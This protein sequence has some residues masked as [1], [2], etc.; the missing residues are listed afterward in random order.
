[1][2]KR[3]IIAILIGLHGGHLSNEQE[4]HQTNKQQVSTV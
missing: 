4:V 3:S 1:M 2:L